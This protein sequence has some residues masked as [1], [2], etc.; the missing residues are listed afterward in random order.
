[1]TS[2]DLFAVP[3]LCTVYTFECVFLIFSPT[4]LARGLTVRLSSL[5]ILDGDQCSNLA[6]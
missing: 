4:S 6:G 3:K 1:M 5:V 2:Q